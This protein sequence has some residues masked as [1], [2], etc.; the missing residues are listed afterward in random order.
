M[1]KEDLIYDAILRVEKRFEEE[2]API[3]KDV[4]ELKNFKNKLVGACLTISFI[5]SF[6]IDYIKSLFK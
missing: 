2:L 4:D 6:C 3:K 5:G 1:N